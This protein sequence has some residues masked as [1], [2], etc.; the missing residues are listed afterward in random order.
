MNTRF[1]VRL[2]PPVGTVLDTLISNILTLKQLLWEDITFI[3]KIRK[4]KL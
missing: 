4:L 1:W 2:L 3:F